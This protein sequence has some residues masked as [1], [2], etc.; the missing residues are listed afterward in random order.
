MREHTETR[1]VEIA[2]YIISSKSTMRQAARKYAISKT[3]VCTD[4]L[5]R[6]PLVNPRLA[7][8]VS[9]VLSGNHAERHVRG[10]EATKR[11]WEEVK[12]NAL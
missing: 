5:V 4:M 3:T 11:R 6:L 8:E 1:A 10:G 2:Q 7:D 9:K 12:R